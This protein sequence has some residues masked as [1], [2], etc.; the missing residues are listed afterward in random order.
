M[1]TRYQEGRR[2]APARYWRCRIYLFSFV[3]Y[4]IKTRDA[5]VTTLDALTYAG[6]RNNLRPVFDHL[7]Y[8]F[9][10]GDLRNEEL[11]R[12]LAASV[13]GIVNFAAESQSIGQ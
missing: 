5:S 3:R 10:E 8:E 4:Q 13:D 1:N 6:S 12:E 7:Q 11:V 9:V 2:Y